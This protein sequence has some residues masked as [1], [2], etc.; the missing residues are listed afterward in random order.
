MKTTKIKQIIWL[1]YDTLDK[2]LELAKKNSLALN[3]MCAELI[4]QAVSAPSLQVKYACSECGLEFK[5]RDELFTHVKSKHP[6]TLL[7]P[8]CL[9][10]N[11]NLEAL[12]KHVIEE[13]KAWKPS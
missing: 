8:F 6:P 3:V 4:K 10:P 7:C 5:S 2:V 9:K 1:D 12:R 11:L 13:I